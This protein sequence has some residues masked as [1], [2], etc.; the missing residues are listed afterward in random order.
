MKSSGFD[1]KQGLIWQ[2]RSQGR[3]GKYED[4]TIY[5]DAIATAT[6]PGYIKKRIIR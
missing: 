2:W 5:C 4:K 1:R 3:G 6:V